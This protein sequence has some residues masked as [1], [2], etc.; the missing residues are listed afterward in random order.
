[1]DPTDDP[2]YS[3]DS[4]EVSYGPPQQMPSNYGQP[5]T[6]PMTTYGA[7]PVQSSASASNVTVV[8]NQPTT[9][10]NQLMATS[11]DGSRTWTTGLFDCFSDITTCKFWKAHISL[12]YD[13]H[14]IEMLLDV[15]NF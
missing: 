5:P 11:L 1:M 4:P 2:K 3:Y 14:P 7:P 13:K 8:V 15:F 12:F 6:Q 10:S 9:Q